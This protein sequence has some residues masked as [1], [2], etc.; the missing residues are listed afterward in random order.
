MKTE[1]HKSKLNEPEANNQKRQIRKFSS[2]EEANE[3]DAKEMAILSPE[4]HLQNATMIT[5]NTNKA[6]SSILVVICFRIF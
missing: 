1:N 4:T 6:S 5:N 3:A 2:F